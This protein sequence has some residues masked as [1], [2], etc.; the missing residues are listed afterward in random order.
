MHMSATLLPPKSNTLN[1]SNCFGHVICSQTSSYQNIA[2]LLTRL[3]I[4][5]FE[6]IPKQGASFSL[7]NVMM[8]KRID[9]YNHER[10]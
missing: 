10:E 9:I 7:I 6:N 2:K 1:G 4:L 3:N 5:K 8:L